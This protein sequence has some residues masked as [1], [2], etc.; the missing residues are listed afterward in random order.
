MGEKVIVENNISSL[1]DLLNKLGISFSEEVYE[2]DSAE[3]R[4]HLE[5]DKVRLVRSSHA[6]AEKNGVYR[7][8]HTLEN[9]G[10]IY[11]IDDNF[12]ETCNSCHNT[13]DEYSFEIAIVEIRQ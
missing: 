3:Y 13:N 6:Q 11:I 4:V 1:K 12:S 8:L 10:L 2:S 9:E 7:V 5:G